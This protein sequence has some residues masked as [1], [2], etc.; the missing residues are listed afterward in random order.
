MRLMNLFG[1]TS[2]EL[3]TPHIPVRSDL[4]SAL[5]LLKSCADEVLVLEGEKVGYLATSKRWTMIIY[6]DGAEV[7]AVWYDDAAGRRFDESTLEKVHR[8]LSRYGA[9]TDWEM[10]LDNGWMRYWFNPQAGVAMV[11]G[12]HKDVIRFNR[13]DRE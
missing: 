4:A 10:R 8:Y 2:Q 6:A 5:T 11:Y 1:N 12:I 3:S 9:L 7:D 13:F